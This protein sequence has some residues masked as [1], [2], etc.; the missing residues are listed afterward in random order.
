MKFIQP[1][2]S[3]GELS[4]SLWSRVD[5]AKYHTGCK[6]MKNF[7]A[8][9][10]GGF[11][12]R[13][14]TKFIG[15]IPGNGRLIPFEFNSD[16]TYM[17]VFTDELMQIVQGDGFVVYPEDHEDAGEVVQIVSPYA[18]EDLDD[19]RVAQ[20]ADTMF[21]SHPSYP[22]YTLT[23]TQHWEWTFTALVLDTLALPP[24]T[25]TCDPPGNPSDPGGSTQVFSYYLVSR[26]GIYRGTKSA[27]ISVTVPDAFSGSV[28]LRWKRGAM[29]S[30]SSYIAPDGYDV[31]RNGVFYFYVP[32][33]ASYPVWTDTG[34]G[35]SGSAGSSS[36][37]HTITYGNFNATFIAGV[38]A[39]FGDHKYAVASVING[40]ESYRSK[41]ATGRTSDPW[42]VGER[43][44]IEWSPVAEATS[45]RIY[46]NDSGQWGW[47]GEF[48][49]S[50]NSNLLRAVTQIEFVNGD[51]FILTIPDHGYVT[52]DTIEV[53]NADNGLLLGETL[54][55]VPTNYVVTMIDADTFTLD[56]TAASS[57]AVITNAEIVA[58]KTPYIPTK[59]IDNNI[60]P[61]V[62]YGPRSTLMYDFSKPDH[63]PTAVGLFQQRLMLANTHDDPTTV[64][65]TR[66]GSLSDMSLAQTARPDDPIE[67][68]PA[69]GKVNGIRHLVP[70]NG[71]LMFTSGS[72]IVLHGADGSLSANNLEF[73]F[74]SY[75]GCPDHP[76]PLP[77]NKSLVFP[78]RAGKTIQNLEFSLEAD[79]YKGKELTVLARHVFK[80]SPLQAWAYQ[81]NPNGVIWAVRADG[82]LRGMTFL[83]DHEVYAWHRHDTQGLFKSVGCITGPVQDDAYFIVARTVSATTKYYVEKMVE[84]VADGGAFLDSHLT[85]AG[86][87]TTVITGL[88]HLEGLS[89]VALAD[90]NVVKDLVVSSGSITLPAEASA[91]HVGLAYTSEFQSL[92]LDMQGDNEGK[93]Q[94]VLGLV[95]RVLDSRGGLLGPT[96]S[97][98]LAIKRPLYG[99]APTDLFTG[100]IEQLLTPAWGR[101]AAYVIQQ[102]SPLPL[103]VLAVV[104]NVDVGT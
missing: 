6:V 43:V 58:V 29:Q 64:W 24:V 93:K 74:D 49:V 78:N 48:F 99:A 14:G 51:P 18:V 39:D 46:K 71:L 65:G 27:T 35:P 50:V 53:T 59:F 76:A 102:T 91:V 17:L 69:S 25:L 67:A 81:Q 96:P 20:S 41:T 90:G 62:S 42:A 3:A 19:V 61:D 104:P 98:T 75:I 23:R 7:V 22:L 68:R 5:F 26:F 101:T 60:D 16:Q 57:D 103:T 97:T 83:P 12:N 80:D 44:T 31:Y 94:A 86:S 32:T 40:D 79:G 95:L 87:P 10:E 1:S 38:P 85:Y 8:L 55:L 84:R 82:A 4:P 47:I 63:Y 13:P 92:G 2:F 30:G 54:P 89:V 11:E 45:Y 9:A 77:I 100:D 37:Y 88:E 34:I 73:N 15:E 33:T 66:T 70:L 72:E 28:T 56:G 36:S 21:L 52:G